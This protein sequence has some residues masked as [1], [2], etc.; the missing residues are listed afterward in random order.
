MAWRP[1]RRAGST[2]RP[3]AK[4]ARRG[5]TPPLPSLL[6][7]YVD[8]AGCYRS[9]PLPFL[10]SLPIACMHAM[11]AFLGGYLDGGGRDIAHGLHRAEEGAGE[12]QL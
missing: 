8:G 1:G 12:V 7:A 4:K 10:L 2:G 11:H 9:A 3:I 5:H 6:H